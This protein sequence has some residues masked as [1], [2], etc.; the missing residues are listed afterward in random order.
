MNR[1]A[2][3]LSFVQ[4]QQPSARGAV[5]KAFSLEQT[6]SRVGRICAVVAADTLGRVLWAQGGLSAGSRP[7]SHRTTRPA[8][9]SR[10]CNAC[11]RESQPYRRTSS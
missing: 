11:R 3:K 10:L 1:S 6:P 5:D 4:P 9:L 7:P 2:G 8:T